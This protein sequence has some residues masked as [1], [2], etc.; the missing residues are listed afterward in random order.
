MDIGDERDYVYNVGLM[1]LTGLYQVL[2]FGTTTRLR[3]RKPYYVA[4]A[5]LL[6]YHFVVSVI[7]LASVWYYWRDNLSSS[8]V[9]LFKTEVGFFTCYQI[10]IIIY[11]SDGI[12]NVL[13]I[14]WY[15]FTSYGLPNKREILDRWRVRSI[16]FTNLMTAV[17]VLG[18][19]SYVGSL[20][21]FRNVKKPLTN[22]DGTVG[23]YREN[24]VNLYL[25]V[26][27][28]TYNSHFS[29]F[30]FAESFFIPSDVVIF[31]MFDTALVSL[32]LA[33]CCQF[34]IVCASFES[35]GYAPLLYFS[36]PETC[37][38]YLHDGRN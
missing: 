20:L 21:L 7:L 29:A 25:F 11:H 38:E 27:A 31:I 24:T 15:G 19:V 37:G 26:S 18:G 23:I 34:Q 9:Y 28:E 4:I 13:S 12:R 32:C 33:I 3:G 6:L 16:R 8:I 17:Y 14:T 5:F 36:T 1:K 22:H 10:W 30:Y 2:D 35:V